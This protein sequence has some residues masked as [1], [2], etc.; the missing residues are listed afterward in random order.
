MIDMIPR[1]DVFAPVL[2]VTL[3]AL[4]AL[5]I[6]GA[7][8]VRRRRGGVEGAPSRRGPLLALTSSVAL[9]AVMLSAWSSLVG[10]VE[11]AFDVRT[12]LFLV[13][14]LTSVGTLI[15]ASAALATLWLSVT[16]LSAARLEQGPFH[17]LVLLASAGM[18][19]AIGAGHLAFLYVGL[20]LSS[21]CLSLLA[22][23]DV[24]RA[25][26][27]EAGLKLHLTGGFASGLML[28]GMALLYGATGELGYGALWAGLDGSDWLGL[29]GL[30]LLLCGLL[31]KLALFPFHQWVSDVFQGA[32]NVTAGYLAVAMPTTAVIVLL[33]LLDEAIPEGLAPVTGLFQVLA[34]A[35]IVVGHGLALVARSVRR[36][37][38][39][40]GI[41]HSGHLALG[42]A[43]SSTEAFEAVLFYV[44]VYAFIV[45]GA[46][47][48]TASFAHGGRDVETVDDFAGLAR[49][50]PVAATALALFLLALAGLPG[51]GG[52]WAMYNLFSA[53]VA[54]G[55]VWPVIVALV[56]VGVSWRYLLAV[57]IAMF[58]RPKPTGRTAGLSTA[59]VIVLGLCTAVVLY[60]GWRPAPGLA[61]VLSG[62][63]R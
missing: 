24:R 59:E 58:A 13:D 19:V 4:V 56:G 48:L 22:A 16:M 17:A 51:T 25:E 36:M 57:P 23:Y 42:L 61:D 46:H 49:V 60:L 26:S 55:L 10:A 5:L 53:A 62:L 54:E 6:D 11:P 43:C 40:A 50:R 2:F 63:V 45:L 12:G 38:A 18:F 34:V 28:F 27:L 29:A 44:F 15:L 3:G 52:F 8:S 47:G 14:R 41:A 39:C 35:S 30:G 21:I 1:W 37:L 7:A 31:F 33:R 20:E 32:P 9:G